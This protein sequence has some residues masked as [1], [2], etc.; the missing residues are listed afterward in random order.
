MNKFLKTAAKMPFRSDASRGAHRRSLTAFWAICGIVLLNAL[1]AQAATYREGNMAYRQGDYGRAYSIMRTLAT[2]GE[3]RAQSNL[4]LMYRAGKG[5]TQDTAEAVKWYRK[6]A[7]QGD[8]SGQFGLGYCY[9]EG[10]GVRQDF[11]QALKWY[12]LAAEQGYPYAQVNL[13]AM[14]STGRG[15]AQDH[16]AAVA[17]HRLQL[18]AWRTDLAAGR[19]APRSAVRTRPC[20]WPR[21]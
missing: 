19:P 4:A 14:Y 5:V 8:V 10:Q 11:A 12:R 20:S 18:S 6:A 16:A 7:D 21:A 1:C 17:W 13:G 2:Q 3:A 9:E 15:V